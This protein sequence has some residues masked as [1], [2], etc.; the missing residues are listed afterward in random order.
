MTTPTTPASPD[1]ERDKLIRLADE[2]AQAFAKFHLENLYG[3][4]KSYTA[5]CKEEADEA[6]Q[7]LIAALLAATTA[8]EWV[9]L[10]D[11]EMS[12]LRRQAKSSDKTAERLWHYIYAD[13]VIAAWRE[14]SAAAPAAGVVA[15][16][17][18]FANGFRSDFV[19]GAPDEQTVAY[20]ERQG[21]ELELAYT[22][23]QPQP[24]AL[25]DEVVKDAL[26]ELG[27]CQDDYNY[28]LGITENKDN[29]HGWLR[30]RASRVAK[31][32]AAIDAD[33]L[34]EGK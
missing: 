4:S 33:M 15:W 7:A 21:V 18:K 12:D 13:L 6:R 30:M 32:R 8:R 3:T 19:T 11:E 2:Y 1:S 17:P 25:P 10:T 28:L 29:L 24:S 16:R 23:S 20:W 34:K 5:N 27:S 31:V 22:H 26:N 9:G 14:K